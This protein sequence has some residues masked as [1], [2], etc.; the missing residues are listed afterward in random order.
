MH[1]VLQA[2]KIHMSLFLSCLTAQ[3]Q[4]TPFLYDDKAG[5]NAV[6]DKITKYIC[7]KK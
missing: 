6:T 4:A 7:H 3:G 5:F 2:N 1:N